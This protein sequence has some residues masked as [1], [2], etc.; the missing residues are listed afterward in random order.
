MR[1]ANA[2]PLPDDFED[3]PVARSHQWAIL[4][5]RYA[6][7]LPYL[8]GRSSDE[9]YKVLI[10]FRV[11][12]SYEQLIPVDR[13]LAD[14]FLRNR[15]F[16]SVPLAGAGEGVM[17]LVPRSAL[18]VEQ[19]KYLG[20]GAHKRANTTVHT[21]D[22]VRELVEELSGELLPRLRLIE[23]LPIAAEA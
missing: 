22:V 4:R 5:E 2:L 21:H 10:R 16:V 15:D 11:I 7:A 14:K 13:I 23:E 1:T 9:Q 17:T 19:L 12:E 18:T 8:D 6:R 20:E 3:S